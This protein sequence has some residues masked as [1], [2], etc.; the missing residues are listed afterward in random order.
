MAVKS[1]SE[2]IDNAGFHGQK[3]FGFNFVSSIISGGTFNSAFL[4]AN[5]DGSSIGV[6]SPTVSATA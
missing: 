6:Q 5:S 1:S 2:Y 3:N 4:T